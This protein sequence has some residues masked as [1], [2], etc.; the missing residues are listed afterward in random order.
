MMDFFFHLKLITSFSSALCTIYNLREGN[1]VQ[2]YTHMVTDFPRLASFFSHHKSPVHQCLRCSSLFHYFPVRLDVFF[3][4]SNL[5]PWWNHT[6]AWRQGQDLWIPF[7]WEWIWFP[8]VEVALKALT[9]C[10]CGI[11]QGGIQSE[12]QLSQET[13]LCPAHP[14]LHCW[15]WLHPPKQRESSI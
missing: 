10:T 4:R 2:I 8:G 13:I 9:C 1:K 3:D 15:K 7:H 11:W 12:W 14:C 6:A 5:S